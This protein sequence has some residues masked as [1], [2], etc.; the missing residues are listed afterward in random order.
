MTSS[1]IIDLIDTS[2]GK[3]VAMGGPGSGHY[4]HAGR[5]GKKGG[6]APSKGKAPPTNSSIPS[7]KILATVT[8]EDRKVVKEAISILPQEHADTIWSI[9]L[10]NT[11]NASAT[12][13]VGAITLSDLGTTGNRIW[14]KASVIHEIGHA[15]MNADTQKLL[16]WESKRHNEYFESLYKE[17]ARSLGLGLS[18]DSFKREMQY[19]EN[20]NRYFRDKFFPSSYS[21]TNHHEFFAES[22]L[23]FVKSPKVLQERHPHIYNYMRDEVFDGVEYTK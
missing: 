23:M 14:N 9:Q 10:G 13:Q 5:P 7:S 15:V 6:S 12:C 4:R 2:L 19:R 16:E 22:Y 17:A 8:G 21:M 11:A 1:D 20:R 18:P 3:Y